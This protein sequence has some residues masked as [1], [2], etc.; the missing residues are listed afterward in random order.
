[1]LDK[2]KHNCYINIKPGA[3]WCFLKTLMPFNELLSGVKYDYYFGTIIKY[4]DI[5]SE[6][7][8]PTRAG[9]CGDQSVDI[10]PAVARRRRLMS[11]HGGASCVHVVTL[12]LTIVESSSSCSHCCAD[13]KLCMNSF[14][15]LSIAFLYFAALSWQCLNTT[16]CICFMY[17][18][19]HV[20]KSKSLRWKL[21]PCLRHTFSLM[22][23]SE[24]R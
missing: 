9:A 3:L 15:R 18:M 14:L 24:P 6:S 12:H 7:C 19:S 22:M 1:M 11:C 16:K 13:L 20:P 21:R 23:S 17:I 5:L 2:T 8:L 10:P 4:W